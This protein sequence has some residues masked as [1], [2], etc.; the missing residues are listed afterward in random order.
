[1]IDYIN[2]RLVCWSEWATRRDDGGLGW[3]R[4]APY[5]REFI[6]HTRGGNVEEINEAAMEIESSVLALRRARP[7]LASV[8]MEFYR[9][10]GS[11]TYKAKM[12][13]ICRDTMYAR[14]HQ[15]H[16]WIMGWLQDQE[17]ARHEQ[18]TSKK[19]LRVAA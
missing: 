3:Q 19:Y 4:E 10:T 8:V 12:L 7:E 17:V 11:A 9:K 18:A 6:G 1:M 5:V 16:V 13:H 14:L 15:A 2:H